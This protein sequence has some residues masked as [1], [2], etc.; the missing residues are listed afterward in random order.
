MYRQRSFLAVIGGTVL[1]IFAVNNLF[2]EAV[3]TAQNLAWLADWSRQ[4]GLDAQINLSI[5][6]TLRYT[7]YFLDA[8]FPLIIFWGLIFLIIWKR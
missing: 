2:T 3:N 8:Y 7:L 5:L 1:A 6:Y 4:S